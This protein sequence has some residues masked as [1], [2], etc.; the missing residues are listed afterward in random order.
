M[1][2][3]G[4]NSAS[5][6]RFAAKVRYLNRDK[7]D[8]TISRSAI[9]QMNKNK[10]KKKE[11]KPH[12]GG[13]SMCGAALITASGKRQSVNQE[14]IKGQR[15]AGTHGSVDIAADS[16]LTPANNGTARFTRPDSPFHISPEHHR[17]PRLCLQKTEPSRR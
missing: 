5:S 6:A 17:S 7:L 14:V 11:K 8:G 2:I 13:A 16:S 15:A 1:S 3:N 12:T 9:G 4:V 10:E